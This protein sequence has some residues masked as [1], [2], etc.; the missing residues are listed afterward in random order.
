MRLVL[1]DF[2]HAGELIGFLNSCDCIVSRIDGE[3]LDV[4]PGP[5]LCLAAARAL[6]ASGRCYGCGAAV[7]ELLLQ[8]A[9]PLCVDCRERSR[10]AGNG[11]LSGNTSLREAWS[12][13]QIAVFVS[14]WLQL[15]PD[16]EV[17]FADS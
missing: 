8:L 13:S 1:A 11:F 15:T 5:S 14:L 2:G 7:P 6:A 12:A 4:E 17:A 10:L 3:A 9:S 16:A